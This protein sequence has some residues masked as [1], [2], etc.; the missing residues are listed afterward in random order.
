MVLAKL[1]APDCD[2]KSFVPSLDHS[3]DPFLKRNWIHTQAGGKWMVRDWANILHHDGTFQSID[4]GKLTTSPIRNTDKI[5]P[6][7]L[8]RLEMLAE[9]LHN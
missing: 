2:G 9:R 4:I 6:H 7:R 5:A 8:E 3:P 1:P